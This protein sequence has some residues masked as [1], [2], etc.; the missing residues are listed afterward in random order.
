M[1]NSERSSTLPYNNDDARWAWE[2]AAR[3]MGL[4][5]ELAS[6]YRTGSHDNHRIRLLWEKIDD[7]ER[8]LASVGVKL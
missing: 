6:L 1:S 7:G 2:E 5:R 8:A 4:H 3:I